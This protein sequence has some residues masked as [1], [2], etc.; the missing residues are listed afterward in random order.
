[1]K[2]A[3][4]MCPA[5]IGAAHCELIKGRNRNDDGLRVSALLSSI[6]SRPWP[7]ALESWSI[8]KEKTRCN[9]QRVRSTCDAEN[10]QTASRFS[11]SAAMHVT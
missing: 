6:L 1:M 2:R 5:G 4:T 8:A 9:G 10:I 3:S 7:H 11:L